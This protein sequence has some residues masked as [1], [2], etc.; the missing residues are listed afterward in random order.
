MALA[1]DT[2][3]NFLDNLYKT[4]QQTEPYIHRPAVREAAWSW[5]K[6]IQVVIAEVVDSDFGSSC[7]QVTLDWL[8]PCF[9]HVI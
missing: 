6:I 1:T 8:H 2:N 7:C 3:T 9:R 4:K 5:V